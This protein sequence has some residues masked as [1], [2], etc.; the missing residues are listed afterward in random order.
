MSEAVYLRHT[1]R[2]GLLV[3]GAVGL[4]VVVSCSCGPERSS[5]EPRYYRLAYQCMTQLG[6]VSDALAHYRTE[7]HG[8]WPVALD[9]L[10]PDYADASILHC[11][12]DTFPGRCSYWYRPPKHEENTSAVVITCERHRLPV[13]T[14]GRCAKEWPG[15]VLYV[16]KDLKVHDLWLALESAPGSATSQNHRP[17]PTP[18]WW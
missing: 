16:T 3:I 8:A 9:E 10:V 4:L 18:G 12:S 2:Q 13:G 14:E 15:I 11:P 7:H 17:V 6:L 5:R 1:R